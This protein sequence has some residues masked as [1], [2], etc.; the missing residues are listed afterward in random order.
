LNTGG[1]YDPGTDSWTA[2]SITDAP[3]VRRAHRAVWSGSEMIVWGGVNGTVR[4]NT[5]GR[6][7]A[8]PG[9]C[10]FLQGFWKNHPEAWPVTELQLGNVTYNQQELLSILRQPVRGN[11]LVLLAH[12]LIAAK[13][14]IANG[15]DGSCIHQTLADAGSLIGDLVVPPV[16]NGYLQ[17]RDVAGIAGVLGSYNEGNL[18][19]PSCDNGSLSPSQAPRPHPI[20]AARP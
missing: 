8:Q 14:N 6:Y 5:G 17:P 16:G 2:T 1:R 9:V 18:C 19:A 3:S 15:A 12:Q 4:L 20:P 11:G 13:L 10:V 7:C